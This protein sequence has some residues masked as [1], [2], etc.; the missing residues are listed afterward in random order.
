MTCGIP[1]QYR[2]KRCAPD[3]TRHTRSRT[4][5]VERR[6][7]A[8][9]TEQATNEQHVTALVERIAGRMA[10]GSTL[11][12]AAAVRRFLDSTL[13]MQC[14]DDL[15]TLYGN[16][17]FLWGGLKESALYNQDWLFCW[18]LQVHAPCGPPPRPRP[19]PSP[20]P[21]SAGRV[22]RRAARVEP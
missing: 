19:N 13:L 11:F 17:V 9:D 5:V 6:A 7:P 22:A 20:R 2:L 1:R 12:T 18:C 16:N 3:R 8:S 14:I 4:V 15:E 21:N 10:P